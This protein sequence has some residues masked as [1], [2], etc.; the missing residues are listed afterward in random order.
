MIGAL[1]EMLAL[2]RQVFALALLRVAVG[3]APRRFAL[4]LARALEAACVAERGD[5]AADM[6]RGRDNVHALRPRARR[7]R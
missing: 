3:L 1:R 6:V 2:V 5:V 4:R 7:R